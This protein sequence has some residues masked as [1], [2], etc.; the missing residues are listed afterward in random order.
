MRGLEEAGAP[1]PPRWRFLLAK[2]LLTKGDVRPARGELG[3][4][5]GAG[6]AELQ[7]AW[8]QVAKWS[9]VDETTSKL[10]RTMAFEDAKNSDKLQQLRE[11]FGDY[12]ARVLEAATR[13]EREKAEAEAQLAKVEAALARAEVGG[14]VA[15]PRRPSR[16]E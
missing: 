8:R 4:L 7:D 15:W 14:G 9:G 3:K 10:R 12:D 1:V 16:G 2:A 5:E 13:A 11:K 6:D